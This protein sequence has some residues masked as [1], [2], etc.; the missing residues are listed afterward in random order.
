MPQTGNIVLGDIIADVPDTA[1]AGYKAKELLQLGAVSVNGAAFSG[2]TVAGLHVNAYAGD[3]TGNGA[4]D[5]LDVATADTV[6]AGSATGFAAY[7]L[8]DPAIIGDVAS[9]V[10]VDA[11]DVSD[12]AA[13]TAHLP[14]P[15]IP[16]VPTGLTITPAGA[17][18]TLSLSGELR[19][20]SGE[21]GG[22]QLAP[23]PS[24]LATVSVLL[25]QPHPAGSSGMTEAILALRFD[26]SILSVSAADIT[27]GSL[28]S[29]GTG[30]RLESAVDQAQGTIGIVLYS[31]T[32]IAAAQA[33][34]LVNIV[35]HLRDEEVRVSSPPRP[36]EAVALVNAVT[37]DGQRFVT[38]VDDGQGQFVLSP[39]LD[40]LA[41]GPASGRFG[42]IRRRPN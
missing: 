17:D 26:P 27:L 1:A 12:L 33:G 24:A 18:P 22:G 42:K 35:F 36:T 30:W 34:S 21:H 38:Q 37:I 23:R 29:S 8:L 20:A 14:T 10:S 28:P 16:A 25:D 15:T 6:A 4:I 2:V 32:P 9:D 39:G 11:G 5:G 13:F 41:A 31:T 7:P 3:V 40:Q 19:V